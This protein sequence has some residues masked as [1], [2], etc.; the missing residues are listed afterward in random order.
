MM[1]ISSL[2]AA[3]YLIEGTIMLS[4]PNFFALYP[5]VVFFSSNCL[6]SSQQAVI[7]LKDCSGPVL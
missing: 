7:S 1:A 6:T 5:N 2:I 3:T 4:S